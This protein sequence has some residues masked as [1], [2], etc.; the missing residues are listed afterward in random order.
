MK[1]HMLRVRIDTRQLATWKAA[2]AKDHRSLSDWIRLRVEG[3]SATAPRAP[4]AVSKG[5]SK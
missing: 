2:A 1:Q 3:V 5:P 4:G